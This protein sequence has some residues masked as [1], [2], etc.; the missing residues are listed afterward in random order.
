MALGTLAEIK[1][2]ALDELDRPDLSAFANDFVT[3]AEGHFNRNLRHRK[4]VTTVDISPASNVY[5]LPTDYLH[6]VRVVEKR[7]I[8]RELQFVTP[9]YVDQ[10]YPDRP[11]GLP[12][13]YTIV[14]SNLFVYP[15]T[16]NDVELTYYQKIPTLVSNDPNWL[17]TDN[18]QIYLRGIQLEA[19]AFINETG[20]PRF[21]FTTTILN[22]LIDEMNEESEMALYS[23]AS[24]RLRGCTP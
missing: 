9:G 17:L 7:S 19:L 1:T 2:A 23:G 13:D 4:M 16:A 24:M 8:R 6:A 12:S 11:S 18:P 3:L 5:A 14:G 10:A 21:Q 15:Y 22:R 20:S